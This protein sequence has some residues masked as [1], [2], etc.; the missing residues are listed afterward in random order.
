MPSRLT[1]F[2]K[3][4]DLTIRSF[5]GLGV[6]LVGFILFVVIA[7]AARTDHSAPEEEPGDPPPSKEALAGAES[8]GES[9]HLVGGL[10]LLAIAGSGLTVAFAKPERSGTALQVAAVMIGILITAPIIGDP[11]NRGGMAAPIDPLFVMVAL[12]GLLAAVVAKPWR[13]LAAS[14]RRTHI[15]SLARLGAIPITWYGVGQALIQRNT[16]PPNADPHHNAHWWAMSALAFAGILVLSGAGLG[17]RGW[18]VGAA[19]VGLSGI[20]F[21]I[22]SSVAVE[23]ASTVSLPWSIATIL[24]SLAVLVVVFRSPADDSIVSR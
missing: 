22:A 13:D 21:G 7:D 24:W 17:L 20:A 10:G 15:L 19:T 11:D 16:F 6:L 18:R 3:S 12:P 23:T 5:A 1:P 9:I 2:S 8:P 14:K 4:R